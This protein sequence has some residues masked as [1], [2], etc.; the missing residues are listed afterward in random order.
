M[1]NIYSEGEHEQLSQKLFESQ[2]ASGKQLT[3]EF[4]DRGKYLIS[5]TYCCIVNHPQSM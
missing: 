5:I 3:S 2:L 4:H 1:Q